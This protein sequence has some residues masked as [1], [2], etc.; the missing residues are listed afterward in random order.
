MS[1]ALLLPSPVMTQKPSSITSPPRGFGSSSSRLLQVSCVT[2]NP[3]RNNNVTC[4]NFRPIKEVN[5]QITHTIPQEKLEIFKSMENWAETTLLPYLKPV[6]DSWQ[7]QDFLPAP[8]TDDAFYDQVREIRERTKEIPDDYFVV[9]VGDM[10]TEE[11]LP[12]YQTTLNTLDGV[13]DET[14]GSLSP[15]AVWIRAWTAEENRHGDLLNKYLYLCGRVDMRHVERTIQYLI[16]SGMDSKFEN[17]PYNGF[18]Y[19][20]FQERATFIS[21]GN[22]ARLATTY[23][24][25]TL[26]KIC[27]TIAADEKRHETAYTKIV[28]KLFE[29][30]PDGT[31]QALASMMK[32]RITMPAHLMHDGR[33]DQLFD[34]YAAVAQRI[35]VYTAADYAGILEFLL[36]RWKV[37]SLGSG[38]SGEGRRAQEYL[39]TLPQRIKR[40]EERANDR[41]KRQSKGS[42]SF[43]WVFGRDVEL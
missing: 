4:N 2:K 18:I 19:T 29:L 42:V 12:T 5:N 20:S 36:R 11:A 8:E 9:L 41:V 43:S 17:N 37:E 6:E 21:H 39:C 16:G 25:T 3:A 38:L 35:G 13:K 22:T 33:D 14:G 27:G 31:V 24:D 28:E 30:D 40:L 7:P 15:W 34:H 32:K 10:I 1:I 26:A 23:G